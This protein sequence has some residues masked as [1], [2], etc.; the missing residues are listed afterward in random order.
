MSEN[1]TRYRSRSAPVAALAAV[2][3]LL[4]CRAEAKKSVMQ[5]VRVIPAAAGATSLWA[6]PSGRY[7]VA[8][9]RGRW[10]R[11]EYGSYADHVPGL[12]K[13]LDGDEL[14]TAVMGWPL[15]PPDDD[16]RLLYVE[17]SP[18]EYRYQVRAVGS[19]AATV[20]SPP[21][22]AFWH[23]KATL[24][25]AGSRHVFVVLWS[26][27]PGADWKIPQERCEQ[28]WIA[29]VDRDS[30]A[31]GATRTIEVT[32]PMRGDARYGVGVAAGGDPARAT[33]ALV[34]VPAPDAS[35]PLWHVRGLDSETLE[36]R[37][38]TAL[39][40]PGQDAPPPQKSDDRRAAPVMPQPAARSAADER[41]TQTAQPAFT[42]D[43]SRLAVV[44]GADGRLAMGA[45]RV[46]VLSAKSGALEATL[47]PEA[48]PAY[49]VFALIPMPSQPSVAA[50]HA[51]LVR[52]GGGPNRS[53]TF[54]GMN[55]IDL[56]QRRRLELVV[57]A[58]LTLEGPWKRAETIAPLAAIVRA[59]TVQLAPSD[60]AWVAQ[61]GPAGDWPSGSG[62][63]AERPEVAT[64]Q[65]LPKAWHRRLREA[66]MARDRWMEE[67][68]E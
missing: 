47:A 66:V 15:G 9:V 40:A 34:E 48:T 36:R 30:L 11:E 26:P 52:D 68:R 8:E 12:L 28:L 18:H 6:S 1:R 21:E 27:V 60:Y 57:P 4:G 39:P 24:G 44:Y 23:V 3:A 35:P 51:E 22:G 59:D 67:A 43:G 46:H 50:L 13:L 37:W 45:S 63:G 25:V 64:W 17:E 56:E 65:S 7:A 61:H 54:F 49:P 33:L 19:E 10:L 38:R 20:L 14:M 31:V 5:H 2:C 41:A 55:A 58:K 16:G 32:T 62:S 53:M 29:S 42:G